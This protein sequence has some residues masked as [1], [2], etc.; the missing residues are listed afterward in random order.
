MLGFAM[1]AGRVIIGT[2][3]VIS[4]IPSKGKDQICLV[5]ISAD[6][7]EGTTK[8]LTFKCEFYQKTVKRIDID[9]AELGRLLGKL[10]APAV[11][12][13]TDRR[14]ADEIL[15]ALGADNAPSD[16]QNQKRKESSQKED[17]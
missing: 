7:S 15:N 4:A 9:S 13:I 10:Y 6:A 11:V 2:N 8:K 3:Q 16:D 14:F 12:A 17:R 5:L 1:R